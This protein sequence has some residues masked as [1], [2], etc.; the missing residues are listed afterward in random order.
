MVGEWVGVSALPVEFLLGEF[1]GLVVFVCIAV[2]FA[3][4]ALVRGG[5]GEH[6]GVVSCWFLRGRW[7][8]GRI[9]V[10][11]SGKVMKCI[12]LSVIPL[13]S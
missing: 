1:G 7:S 3:L 6:G 2:V 12:G 8:G 5:L 10:E 9:G 11:R 4:L 13:Q